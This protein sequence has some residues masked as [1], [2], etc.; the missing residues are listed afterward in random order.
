MQVVKVLT[1]I[2][3]YLPLR[4]VLLP[5]IY[6]S[7]KTVSGYC[8]LLC[9]PGLSCFI[10]FYHYSN[11]HNRQSA[12]QSAPPVPSA[13]T[14]FPLPSYDVFPA[15]DVKTKVDETKE[16][17]PDYSAPSTPIANEIPSYYWEPITA[18]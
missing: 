5:Y 1:R 17:P 3:L 13:V 9:M 15:A 8:N 10:N 12:N 2:A 4:T 16:P 7:Y 6:T 18:L 11:H 14:P